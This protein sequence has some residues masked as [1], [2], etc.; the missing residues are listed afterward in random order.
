MLMSHTSS[1]PSLHMYLE[2]GCLVSEFTLC[3][4]L[5]VVG[6]KLDGPMLSTILLCLEKHFAPELALEYLENL[7]LLP[8]FSIA[9]SFLESSEKQGNPGP[10]ILYN[11]FS[12][13]MYFL[14]VFNPTVVILTLF[15]KFIPTFFA[16]I[17]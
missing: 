1:A 7:I 4:S 15:F 6:N 12:I 2:I 11:H 3:T 8:R 14:C 17:I 9:W 10:L 5:I 13:Y 16:I